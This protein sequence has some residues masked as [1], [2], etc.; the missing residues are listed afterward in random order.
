MSTKGPDNG[1]CVICGQPGRLTKD[2]VP[3]KGCNNH[4]NIVLKTFGC[5]SFKTT[6]FS[7]ITAI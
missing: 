6:G 4:E 1:C 7:V 5:G 2:H 3:P